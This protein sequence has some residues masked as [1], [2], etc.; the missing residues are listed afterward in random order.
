MS[1][2]FINRMLGTSD[3]TTG[4]TPVGADGQPVRN[5]SDRFGRLWV[6]LFQGSAPVDAVNPLAVGVQTSVLPIGAATEATLLTVASNTAGTTTALGNISTESTLLSVDAEVTAAAAVLGTTADAV[7]RI[8]GAT[9]INAK[10]RGLTQMASNSAAAV[11]GFIV[12]GNT[13]SDGTITTSH[14]YPVRTGGRARAITNLPTAVTSDRV[15]GATYSLQ[16]EAFVALSTPIAGEDRANNIMVTTPSVNALQSPN[17][18]SRAHA[19]LANSQL[20]LAKSS[21]GNLYH[22]RATNL[23]SQWLYLFVINKATNPSNGDAAYTAMYPVPPNASVGDDWLE[24]GLSMPAGIAFA[25]S[26][27]TASLTLAAGGQ[28]TALYA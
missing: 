17:K 12:R 27:T 20:L 6:K 15:V 7:D 22:F 25:W 1:S 4:I 10:L 14:D 19:N 3:G 11:P 24:V 18:Y 13:L 21:A 2:N 26:T 16:G 8:G 23:T 9:T 28:I 5:S